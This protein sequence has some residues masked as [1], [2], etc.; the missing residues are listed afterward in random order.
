MDLKKTDLS[1]Y[2]RNIVKLELIIKSLQEAL[3]FLKK[4]PTLAEEVY[5]N[6]PSISAWFFS[7]ETRKRFSACARSLASG[8]KLEKKYDDNYCSVERAF[9]S[10]AIKVAVG[11]EVVCERVVVETIQHAEEVRPAWVEEKVEWKCK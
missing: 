8:T 11:R 3:E 9:G 5:F 2:A 7:K 1:G 10:V 4:H 6:P